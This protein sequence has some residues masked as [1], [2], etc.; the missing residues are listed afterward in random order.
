MLNNWRMPFMEL[1]SYIIINITN[2]INNNISN[3]W[4]SNENLKIIN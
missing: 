1:D 4:N 3:I 2:D